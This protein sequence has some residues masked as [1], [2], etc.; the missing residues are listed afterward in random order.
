MQN[1]TTGSHDLNALREKLAGAQ[2]PEYWR[3]LEEIAETPEF[4]AWIDDEF[5]NRSSLLQLDRRD[6]I[7]V[8]GASMAL[9]GLSGCRMLPQEKIV[10][11]V[12]QPEEMVPGQPL[13][14]S[15]TALW[16][17]YGVGIIVES[18]EGRPTKIEGNPNHPASLGATNAQVQAMIL[19]LY[20][21]DRIRATTR[22]GGLG[23]YSE[24]LSVARGLIQAPPAAGAAPIRILTETVTSPTLADLLTRIQSRNPGV[25]W[26]QYDPTNRARVAGGSTALFGSEVD[27]IYHLDRAT[28]ILALDGDFLLN[29]PG[30]IRYARDFISGRR[31]RKGLAEMNRL[32]AVEST[33]TLTGA[34]ADHRLPVKPSDVEAFGRALLAALGGGAAGAAAPAGTEKFLQAV[35]ED[36]RAAAASAVVIPGDNQPAAV[37]AIAHAINAQLG[38]VGATVSYIPAVEASPAN[39]MESLQSLVADMDAGQVQA[40]FILGG[41]PAYTAP[42]DLPFV[43]ALKKVPLRARLGMIPDETA[44]ACNWVL[45]ETHF[46]EAWGDARAYD[47]T[48]SIVQ[49]LIHPLYEGRSAIEV[50]SALFET[51]RPG[52]D[53]VRDYWRRQPV[54]AGGNFD[55]TWERWLNDGV[56]PN[57]AA[58]AADGVTV[59]GSALAAPAAAVTGD[60]VIFHPDPTIWD[61]RFANNAWLQET[62]KPLTK[63]VWDNAA[64]ISA[65]MAERLGVKPHDYIQIEYKGRKLSAPCWVSPGHPDGCVTL[66]FGYGRENAGLN[67]SGIGV[68]AFALW[69]SDT[70][71]YGGGAT[72]TKAANAYK[73]VTTQT[74]WTMHGREII[75][76]KSFDRWKEN[77]IAV[78]GEPAAHQPVAE[79]GSG[80]AGDTA[81]TG[82]PGGAGEDHVIIDPATREPKQSLY[83]L[84]DEYEE[85]YPNLPQWGMAI[86]LTACIG[87]NACAVACQSENNIPVVGKEEVSRGRHMNW[88]RIDRY[89]ESKAGQ[90]NFANPETLFMPVPCMH[91]EK[92]PCEP[93]CPVGATTHSHEGL[94]QMVYNRCVGTRY[95]SNNCP[96]KV[97]RFNFLNYANHHD[98]PVTNLRQNPDVTVRG[99]G[100]MEKCTYCVQRIN[101][102]RVRAKIEGRQPSEIKDG[103]VIPACAQACPTHAISFGNI[104]DRASEVSQWKAEGHNY[105]LLGELNTTPR[106][107]YLARVTN[108]NPALASE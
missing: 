11:Y 99:R 102:V 48:A 83:N 29:L 31:V 47:G 86:D 63:L 88:I 38:A 13:A 75:A 72:I 106:T 67:G 46:L 23:T 37:H 50:L 98:I 103:E 78:F 25:R 105:S 43:S 92:A 81:K 18:H 85:K 26:H 104:K 17:G 77:P 108:P 100:V 33:P 56:I 39:A 49:P 8:M 73:L 28:R 15:T 94:N 2:G 61:G 62:P 42:A 41:N 53:I 54:A 32:Y 93:V 9:A 20:D 84:T 40:V 91:C 79:P 96:Y 87:C 90:D 22:E 65:K 30:S 27:A 36:F 4:Q 10:P 14:F 16:N 58:Q 101:R 74:Q 24:F 60:E 82:S 107:T 45:P 34:M 12:Q 51:A 68:N 95:C 64:L 1:E 21:P 57:T 19:D 71:G 70:G 69:T 44:A 6:F 5:P 66:H 59:S 7:K 55:Q 35:V 97:R 76:K 3:G 89:Y 80:P 52:R